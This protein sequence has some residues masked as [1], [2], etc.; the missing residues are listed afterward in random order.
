M[1][2]RAGSDAHRS[3]ACS[4]PTC[5]H[6]APATPMGQR[7]WQLP[8]RHHGAVRTP[9]AQLLCQERETGMNPASP[10]KEIGSLHEAC[11]VPTTG[12]LGT[13]QSLPTASQ[14]LPTDLAAWRSL[15]PNLTAGASLQPGAWACA[16]VMAGRQSIPP[17]EDLAGWAD[18]LGRG[19]FSFAPSIRTAPSA[20][21]RGQT[22]SVGP[23][24]ISL[25]CQQCLISSPHALQAAIALNM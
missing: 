11:V 9:P 18:S 25:V 22:H 10:W 15:S 6:Q 14:Q 20:G 4:W 23:R 7:P 24:H 8:P 3:H 19:H 1:G 12:P 16:A 13:S 21:M 5:W 2:S 17:A